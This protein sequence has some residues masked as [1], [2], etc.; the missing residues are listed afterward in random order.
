M[1]YG[2]ALI[3]STGTRG[4][5]RLRLDIEPSIR[6][7]HYQRHMIYFDTDSQG[8]LIVRVL[9]DRMELDRHLRGE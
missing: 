7:F 4:I 5:G 6:A 2:L 1:R 8:I 3:C 9:H